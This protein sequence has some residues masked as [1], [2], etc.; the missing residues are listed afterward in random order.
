[1]TERTRTA[2]LALLK[3]T[4]A[5]LMRDGAV[6]ADDADLVADID[7][8]IGSIDP[9]S[10]NDAERLDVGNYLALSTT[11]VSWPTT[12]KIDEWMMQEPCDRPV[13]IADTHYGWLLCTIPSSFGERSEIPADLAAVLT[14][15]QQMGCD[16]LILDRD[17]CASERLPCFEW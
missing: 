17:A 1:M 8:A 16:Y 2:H 3:R 4:K 10:A 15:A 5:A 14:F 7:C 13:S 6:C 11:H 12:L 9:A